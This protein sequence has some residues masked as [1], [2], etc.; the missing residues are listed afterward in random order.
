M[1]QLVVFVEPWSDAWPE[2]VVTGVVTGDVVVAGVV[3][4]GDAACDEDELDP[5]L[6]EELL[7]VLADAD[8][9]DGDEDEDEE[10]PVV[11][12]VDVVA[13]VELVELVFAPLVS[14]GS[15]VRLVGTVRC[16]EDAGE[17]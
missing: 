10:L 14:N 13:V 4:T 6:L 12:G 17:R 5:A 11:L 9:D 16:A 7:P 8:A 15:R 1:S 3:A 2:L